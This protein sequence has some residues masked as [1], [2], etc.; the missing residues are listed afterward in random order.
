[1]GALLNSMG[2]GLS[3]LVVVSATLL[4]ATFA[5]QEVNLSEARD[6]WRMEDNQEE[7]RKEEKV[8]TLTENDHD[9]QVS[10]WQKVVQREDMLKMS[11]KIKD[12]VSLNKAEEEPTPTQKREAVSSR[13]AE[14]GPTLTRRREAVSSRRTEEEPT[15]TRRR[16][17]VSS[18]RAEAAP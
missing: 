15:P 7:R 1:M 6:A 5:H 8:E 16:K 14:E 10:I 2:R 18:R 9:Q 13:R 17:A 12:A 3:G 11:E 4:A